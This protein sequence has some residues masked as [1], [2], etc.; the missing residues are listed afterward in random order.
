MNIKKAN[1]ILVIYFFINILR[2]KNMHLFCPSINIFFQ[3][4]ADLSELMQEK[5]YC[6]H[7][8]NPEDSFEMLMKNVC[9]E[10][11]E[12]YKTEKKAT[13]YLAILG[14]KMKTDPRQK[15]ERFHSE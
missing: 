12:F 2:I 7:I 15:E 4:G 6:G 5:N 3:N 1:K 14:I 9:I 10:K 11:S 13:D 8:V